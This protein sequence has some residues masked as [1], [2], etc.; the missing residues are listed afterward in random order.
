MTNKCDEF[1]DLIKSNPD[2]FLAD[3]DSIYAGS[4]YFLEFKYIREEKQAPLDLEDFQHGLKVLNCVV[5][6]NH[7]L[8]SLSDTI[9]DSMGTIASTA[10]FDPD[11]LDVL[12]LK[13]AQPNAHL[14]DVRVKNEEVQ[15]R[16]AYSLI[17][18]R[19][20]K[21][22]N[23][24]IEPDLI[25]VNGKNGNHHHHHDSLDK[26]TN[27][28]LSDDSEDSSD[29]SNSSSGI[30]SASGGGGVGHVGPLCNLLTHS[31]IQDCIILTNT[32]YEQECLGLNSLYGGFK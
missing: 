12:V 3:I 19:K 15:Q 27:A 24:S 5:D 31:E 25:V 26:K 32:D 4:L 11:E 29:L 18:Q 30:V 16:Y 1:L 23:N 10:R 22:N 14:Q 20:L 6:I 21:N 17:T 13:L 2:Q 7:M 28:S 8:D 9:S